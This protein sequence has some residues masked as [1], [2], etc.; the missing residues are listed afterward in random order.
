MTKIFLDDGE[1]NADWTRQTWD[2]PT[3]AGQFLSVIGG[4]EA[5]PHFLSLPSAAAMPE[6]LRRELEETGPM[7][8]P[9]RLGTLRPAG[10]PCATGE[11]N[12]GA[13]ALLDEDPKY[14]WRSHDVDFVDPR[15]KRKK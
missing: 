13:D 7:P 8:E 14:T 1:E 5:L 10:D 2:L 11:A 3:D 6:K 9:E 12:E 15:E 4:R